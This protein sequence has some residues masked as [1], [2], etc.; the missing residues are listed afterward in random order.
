MDRQQ[1]NVCNII[2]NVLELNNKVIKEKGLEIGIDIPPSLELNTIPV[3]LES[4]FHNLITNAI[5]Y[6]TTETQKKIYIS[7]RVHKKFVSLKVQDFGLGIDLKKYQDKV[8]KLGARFH[9]NEVDGHGMGL[10][11][12]KH[13][14]EAMGGKID[15]QSE[16]NK[17]T[18]FIVIFYG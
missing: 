2:N 9:S 4:I 11:M 6:G 10:F 17:G 3:Y 18:T 13:Q 7:S 16:V 14:V 8:F 5:K 12:T 15:V 1:T